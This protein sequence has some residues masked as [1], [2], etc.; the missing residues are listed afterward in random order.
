MAVHLAN[1]IRKE[2]EISFRIA[3]LFEAPTVAALGTQLLSSLLQVAPSA[4]AA[5]R[6]TLGSDLTAE[7]YLDPSLRPVEARGH[8]QPAV[9]FCTGASGFL[10]VYLL[11]ELLKTTRA[12]VY[13]L[14]RAENA[15]AGYGRLQRALEAHGLYD[16]SFESRIR[17]VVGELS[18][19]RL[20]LS[21]MD[22][23]M[24]SS[25]VDTIY[26][27]GSKVNFLLPYSSLKGD[28]VD[29]TREILKLAVH[30]KIKAVHYT[31]TGG[32]FDAASHSIEDVFVREGDPL[33]DSKEL[34]MG[35][36]Q[37]KWVADTMMLEAS[38]RGLPVS[39]YRPS[40]IS[41]DGRCGTP[42]WRDFSSCLI[43][44]CI[45]L[46][47]YPDLDMIFDLVPV[48][49]SA[50]AM[51]YISGKPEAL[52]KPFHLVHPRPS[53]FVPMLED[54][55]SFGYP[56]EKLS[57]AQW[58]ER[59]SQ[60]TTTTAENALYPF[61]SLFT[62]KITRFQRPFFELLARMERQRRVDCSKTIE[63][64][65]G[66]GIVCRDFDEEFI[67]EQLACFVK[68]AFI[69]APGRPMARRTNLGNENGPSGLQGSPSRPPP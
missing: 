14:V 68:S 46:E 29:G 56:M 66:S 47:A 26:H 45:Q 60:A 69:P 57:Y 8:H 54:V 2:L 34:M 36:V 42:P 38:S 11:H 41:G 67:H 16:R 4:P 6:I 20:G 64:L 37:S 51:V 17:P 33:I 40:F 1:A 24:L 13:C 50:K 25:E 10:G 5:G 9:V 23:Q 19:P 48:D 22:Y 32:V 43:K 49:F 58:L 30:K 12:Q 62:E 3:S 53:R 59:L 27:N 15:R 44:G 31:S 28:N 65:E 61:M 21:E 7:A 55:R 39:I 35:Y 18:R 63:A 52:G